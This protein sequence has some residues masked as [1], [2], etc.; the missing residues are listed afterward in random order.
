MTLTARAQLE[1]EGMH[2]GERMEKSASKLSSVSNLF[3][4][5]SSADAGSLLR[6]ALDVLQKHGASVY[7]D[8]LDPDARR[9]TPPEFGD[10][11]A[12]AI[13]DTGHLVVL[14]TENTGDSR[15][16]PWELGLAHGIHG[17]RRAA[18]WPVLQ[19]PAQ[20]PS[21]LRQEYLLAY[22]VLERATLMGRQGE[23]WVVRDPRASPP[24]YWTLRQWL[25]LPKG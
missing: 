21:W 17:Q 12:Q 18:V 10:F 19:N 25:S 5:H 9:L 6:G 1:R 24:A 14:L 16:V 20:P 15:W 2:L 13:R 22:P 11:F 8:V 23:E 7:A 3:L 4:S